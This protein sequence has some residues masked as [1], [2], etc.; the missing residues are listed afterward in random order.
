MCDKCK[1][2]N[3]AQSEPAGKAPDKSRYAAFAAANTSPTDVTPSLAGQS[4]G[5]G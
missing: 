4:A 2:P 5:K 1:P 3:N